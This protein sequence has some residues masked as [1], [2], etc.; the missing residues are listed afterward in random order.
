MRVARFGAFDKILPQREGYDGGFA[1]DAAHGR[2]AYE[3]AGLWFASHDLAVAAGKLRCEPEACA[4]A[5]AADGVGGDLP[6]SAHDRAAPR[7]SNL[8]VFAA[9]QGDCASEPSV[10]C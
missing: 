10:V 7:T 8:P 5:D 3:V 6:A 1:D 9:S 4:T 2:V